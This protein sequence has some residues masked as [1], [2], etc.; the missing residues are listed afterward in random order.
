[1][2]RFKRQLICD[3]RGEIIVDTLVMLIVSVVI[4]MTLIEF[5]GVFMTFQNVNFI[6]KRL[7]RAVEVSGSVQGLDTTFDEL[8]D[9]TK[10]AGDIDYQIQASYC[11]SGNRRIQLRDTFTL[12]VS[13]TYYLNIFTPDFAPPLRL[14]FPLTSRVIGMSEVFYKE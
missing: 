5:L 11:D 12:T 6:G 3:Q 7:A 1:M 13:Y 14:T 8:C 9:K 2:K 10:M 4:L